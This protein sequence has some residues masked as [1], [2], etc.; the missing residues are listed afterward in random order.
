MEK[1]I[2]DEE[3]IKRAEEISARRKNRIPASSI[4]IKENKKLSFLSRISI[5][6]I[7]SICIFGI[8][9]FINQNYSFAIEKIK[10]VISNDADFSVIYSQVNDVVKNIIN[11]NNNEDDKLNSEENVQEENNNQPSNV[12]S[13]EELSQNNTN[14]TSELVNE[15]GVI[16]NESK[17][18]SKEVAVGGGNDGTQQ[19]QTQQDI[20]YIKA[21]AS[22][23]KPVVGTITSR[24]GQRTPT[25]IISAN[26]GGVDIGANIG[27]DIIASMEGTVELVS[28]EGDYGIHLKITKGEISTLYAHCSKIVVKQGD[29]ITQGQKIAEVGSTGK[30][31][32]PHL[33]FEIR[34][35]NVTIN[36][37]EILS[38]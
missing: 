26:H 24:Y 7:T 28:T 23:I 27:T 22:F 16:L 4:N 30:A 35:N 12:Q 33:H 34:R 32:G 31:T 13:S 38:L 25:E 3:R 37:E 5:Q 21:N 15:S 8:I 14:Q 10:P 9:Y 36:P 19:S 29:N 18:A 20:A 17:E 6:I 2:S 11:K 1:I